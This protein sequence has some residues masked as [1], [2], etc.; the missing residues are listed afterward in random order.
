MSERRAYGATPSTVFSSKKFQAAF[1][2]NYQTVKVSI[3]A[4]V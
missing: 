2:A 3:K 4:T 1:S